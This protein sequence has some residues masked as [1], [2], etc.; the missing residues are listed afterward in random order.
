M[1]VRG[2]VGSTPPSLDFM[3]CNCP[4]CYLVTFSVGVFRDEH[5][6]LFVF[7]R[8]SEKAF[9][10]VCFDLAIGKQAGDGVAP[11]LGCERD[12]GDADATFVILE[13]QMNDWLTAAG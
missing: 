4:S 5:L 8:R 7:A 3:F 6:D 1:M 12:L 10:P 11:L 13:R 2:I 9:I